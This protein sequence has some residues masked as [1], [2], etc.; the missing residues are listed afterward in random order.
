[1]SFHNR[2]SV[3]V[4]CLIFIKGEWQIGMW[5]CEHLCWDDQ[6]GDDFLYQ[7]TEPTHWANLPDD[8]EAP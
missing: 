5:N 6:H 8:P 7:P 3:H 2:Q 4:R 1:M